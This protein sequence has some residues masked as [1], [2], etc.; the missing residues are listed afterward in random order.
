MK[1]KKVFAMLAVCAMMFSGCESSSI[2]VANSEDGMVTVTA[3]NAEEK[4]GGLGYVTVE[5]GQKLEVKA[6]LTGD[7][8]IQIEV[9]LEEDAEEALLEET[10]TGSDT[11]EFAMPA[12][13]YIVRIAAEKGASG[14][15]TIDGK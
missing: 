7:S 15:M 5:D 9:L 10:I 11:Y 2:T 8:G 1:N 4:S 14:S 13:E 12:G 6:E 3:E